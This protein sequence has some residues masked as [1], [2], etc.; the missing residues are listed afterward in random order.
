MSRTFLISDTHFTHSGICKFLRADGVTKVRPW[1]VPE[2]M[3][4]VLIEN[5]NRVVQPNDR[6]YHLG[7]VTMKRMHLPILNR[8]NGRKVLIRGNHDIWGIEDYL[9][10]FDDVCGSRKLDSFILSHYPIHPDSISHWCKGN[11]CGHIHQN[12]VA[13]EYQG[14]TIEDPRYFNVSVE[15]INYTP[16]DLEVI[17]AEFAR[18]ESTEVYKHFIGNPNNH[19]KGSR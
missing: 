12:I 16:I 7:D 8:L 19:Y 17:K 10:Y 9:P 4:E 2:E 15:N 1:N 14:E 18:R 5:W 6:V 13:V 3:D 11:I